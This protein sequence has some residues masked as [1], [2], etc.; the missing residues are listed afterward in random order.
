MKPED[1]LTLIQCDCKDH[2]VPLVKKQ[3]AIIAARHIEML[4]D[5]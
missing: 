5:L 2:G 3:V 1:F 4:Q